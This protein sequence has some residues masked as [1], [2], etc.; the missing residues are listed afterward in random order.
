MSLAT[1]IVD[2]TRSS[3]V[4]MQPLERVGPT[5]GTARVGEKDKQPPGQYIIVVSSSYS[6]RLQIGFSLPGH[7]VISAKNVDQALERIRSFKPALVIS[8][9]TVQNIDDGVTLRARM[10]DD[11]E[12]QDIKFIL[13]SGSDADVPPQLIQNL[14][15]SFKISNVLYKQHGMQLL[16]QIVSATLEK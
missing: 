7:M 11:P 16:P 1:P 9:N 4:G 10:L 3:I 2:P 14:L 6:T 5:S 12:M 15:E 13:L 8:D